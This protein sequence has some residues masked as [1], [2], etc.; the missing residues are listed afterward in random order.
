[1]CSPALA[2]V[3][4]QAFSQ[5]QAGR[6][7]SAVEEGNADIAEARGRD[8]VA[9]GRVAEDRRRLEGSQ[10][11]GRQRA[12]QAASGVIVDEDSAALQI[13]DTARTTELDALTIRSNAQREKFG[14]DV[15]AQSAKARAK[16]ARNRS[17]LQAGKTVLGGFSPAGGGAA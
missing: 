10:L 6:F 13:E 5:I 4:I 16:Q 15:E 2:G 1:M 17:V 8:A 3:G 11:V 14:F 12:Q 9:R 7:N